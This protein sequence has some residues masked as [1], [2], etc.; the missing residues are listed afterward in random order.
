MGIQVVVTGVLHKDAVSRISQNGNPY[1]TCSVRAE[2]DGQTV[3]A[4]VICFN[5]A[6]QEELLRLKSGD[7]I[8]VHGKAAPKVYMKDDEAR[9]SLQVTASAVHSLQPAASE[10]SFAPRYEAKP[11]PAARPATP[12][13]APKPPAAKA[14]PRAEDHLADDGFDDPLDF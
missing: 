12:K 13:K 9:P 10:P 1:V 4:N 2:Q 6:A 14:A 11:R 3:W 8:S 5:E 7:A